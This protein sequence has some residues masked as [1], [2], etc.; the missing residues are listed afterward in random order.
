MCN[1]VH[2][3]KSK[4]YKRVIRVS[5]NQKSTSINVLKYLHF[6]TYEKVKSVQDQYNFFMF[7]SK[8][9]L[10]FVTIEFYQGN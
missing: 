9:S 2:Y 10:E 5:Q 3:S 4:H 8:K 6:F 1:K 7:S